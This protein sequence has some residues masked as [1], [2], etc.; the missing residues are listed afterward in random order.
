M[1][2]PRKMRLQKRVKFSTLLVKV[3]EKPPEAYGH[4]AVFP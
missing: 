1:G 4:R 3:V 2:K